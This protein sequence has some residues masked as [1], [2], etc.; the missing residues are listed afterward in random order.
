MK[1]HM[2]KLWS[3]QKIHEFFYVRID[4]NYMYQKV[5]I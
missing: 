2:V 3:I 5:N 4:I 1:K